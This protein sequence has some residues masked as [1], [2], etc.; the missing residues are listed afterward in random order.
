MR[1][2]ALLAGAGLTAVGALARP[3]I[4]QSATRQVLRFVPQSDLTVL[5]PIWTT[6]G[7]T[8]AHAFMV[9]DTLFGQTGPEHRFACTPQMVEG[10]VVED[11]GQ[12][13]RLRLR[14]GLLFHDGT[15]VLGR[16]CVASI[17]RWSARDAFGQ[18]LLGRT[19]EI[20]A[21]DDRTIVFRLKTPFRLLPDALGRSTPNIC[22]M[23]PERLALTDPFKQV[24]E[25]TGSGPFRF[26]ADE[27]VQGSMFVYER[28]DHYRPRPDGEPEWTAGP[29]IVH[30]DRVEWHIIPDAATAAAALQTGEIDGW[31]FPAIDLLPLLRADKNIS[32]KLLNETGGCAVMQV[33]HLQPPFDNPAVR[34]ALL[35][36]I[37][38]TEFMVAAKGPDAS[39]WRVPVGFFPP[40]SPMASDTGMSALTGERR[41][42]QVRKD[43]WAAGYRDETIVLMVPTD[44]PL[45]KPFGDVAA[46]MFTKVAMAVDYQAMDIGTLAQRRASKKPP[47]QG[48]WNAFSTTFAGIDFWTPATHTLLRGN[49]EHAAAGWPTSAA[50]EALRDAWLDAPD[51][52][53][54]KELAAKLQAQAFLDVPYYPLG[55]LYTHSA[56]R[57]D[58]TGVLTGLPLFWNIRRA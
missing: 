38:Q 54:Q 28:F 19:N 23:M 3:A 52:P 8:R 40:A 34:R 16:D 41:L 7:A 56:Y 43:L 21:P 24:T 46:D 42:D 39:L 18:A 4:G 20:S 48:G 32:V 35:G 44:L 36:A 2:R 27:R 12:T 55:L 47:Q 57:A 51:L 30:F 17:R 6:S 29:K 49:G 58:L 53:A 1:R 9:F 10:H 37:D 25:M 50:I 13:W 11:D 33:N 31:E 22:V 26:K 45:I 5:D 14:D 15:P